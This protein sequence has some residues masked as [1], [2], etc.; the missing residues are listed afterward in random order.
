MATKK[1]KPSTAKTPAP[2]HAGTIVVRSGGEGGGTVAQL[3][4]KCGARGSSLRLRP[5]GTWRGVTCQRCWT[6]KQGGAPQPADD[7]TSD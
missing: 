1:K 6:V 5:P 3:A 4:S 7:A 2:Y